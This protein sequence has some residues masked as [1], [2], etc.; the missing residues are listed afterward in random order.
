MSAA[1]ALAF[2]GAAAG[3]Y[4]LLDLLAARRAGARTARIRRRAEGR[5]A[6]V[7]RLLAAAGAA[8]RPAGRSGVPQDLEARIVAAGSP[9]GLGPRE[10]MA[11]K[12]AGA[13]AAGVLAATVG[14]LLP[15]RLGILA[16]VLGPVGGFLGPDLWLRRRAAER[17]RRVR[18]DLPAMLDLLRVSVQAGLPLTAALGAVGRRSSGPLATEW[19]RVGREVELGVSSPSAV[20]RMVARIP[21][22]EVIALVGALERAT[23]HGAPLSETLA[24]QAREARHARRRRIQEEAAKAGPKI[25]LVVALLLVPSVLLLVAAALASA[26]LG[27]GRS[28]AVG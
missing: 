21:T 25:Q 7:L 14:A 4:G 6:R 16:M 22:P 9:A 28:I 23:R 24:A 3:A 19:R 18:A 2:L 13:V 20:R 17:G 10:T 26:L 8:V 5:G 1:G 11:A 12:L 15:G 27:P